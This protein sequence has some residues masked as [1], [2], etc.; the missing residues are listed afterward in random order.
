MPAPAPAPTPPPPVEAEDPAAFEACTKE[1][2]TLGVAFK[3]LP[4]IDDGDGCGIDRPIAVTALSRSVK[5]EPEATLRCDTAL[6][7]ARMTRDMLEPAARLAMPEKGRLTAVHHASAYVCRNRNGAD[8]GKISE[9][10]RGNAIDI[11][12]L[13]FDKGTE[14]MS[15]AKPEDSDLPAAFQRSLNAFACLYFRTVL[16]PGSDAA[17]QDHLHLDIIERNGDFRYCR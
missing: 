16:S 13:E 10:A 11:S 6:E 15:I 3:P 1:L 14:P 7:L 2:S 12:S 5:L 9:H 4:R 8:D 17:H